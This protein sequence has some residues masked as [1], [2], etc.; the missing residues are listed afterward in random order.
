MRLTSSIRARPS[1]ACAL[2]TRRQEVARRRRAGQAVGAAKLDLAGFRLQL[3]LDA[4]PFDPQQAFGGPER[5]EAERLTARQQLPAGGRGASV[6]VAPPVLANCKA[7]A[8]RALAVALGQDLVDREIA[9][10]RG[11]GNIDREC[12][13]RTLLR[14]P[15]VLPGSG[16]AGRDDGK[17]Q[18]QQECVAARPM[19]H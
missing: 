6:M 7:G 5:G 12:R 3:L 2:S 8:R 4:A 10:R 1:R 18:R 14:L 9:R 11:R 17:R 15:D 13:R 16:R 19:E